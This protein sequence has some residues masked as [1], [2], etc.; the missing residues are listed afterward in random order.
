MATFFSSVDT[1]ELF[2][3]APNH[4]YY[5]SLIVNYEDSNKW[6]AKVA[7]MGEI[8]EAGEISVKS[9]FKGL[10]SII[11]TTFKKP[12]SSKQEVMFTASFEIVLEEP[13]EDF[14]NRIIELA[15][16]KAGV[17]SHYYSAGTGYRSIHKP[18]SAPGTTNSKVGKYNKNV[19]VK[20]SK[21]KGKNKN[22]NE[23]LYLGFYSSE[24]YRVLGRNSADKFDASNFLRKLISSAAI[25]KLEGKFNFVDIYSTINKT[26]NGK[27]LGLL[28]LAFDENLDHIINFYTEKTGSTD[29]LKRDCLLLRVIKTLDED[30]KNNS[31]L[32]TQGLEVDNLLNQ[33]IENIYEYISPLEILS[34][35]DPQE[36]NRITNTDLNDCL[37]VYYEMYEQYISDAQLEITLGNIKPNNVQQEIDYA[38]AVDFD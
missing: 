32:Q 13:N 20:A 36:F 27:E 38:G 26:L 2:E 35:L 16:P 14:R 3:N 33:L 25:P 18:Y 30:I 21:G 28:E 11:N 8:E 12:V 1:G 22:V 29:F 31:L 15:K 19:N 17:Y 37:E 5:V 6:C 24:N 10:S 7:F 9:S 23:E 4:N 34:T